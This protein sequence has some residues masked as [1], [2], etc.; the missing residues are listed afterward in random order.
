M[1]VFKTKAGWVK[2]LKDKNIGPFETEREAKA[3]YANPKVKAVKKAED[4]K[5]VPVEIKKE[6]VQKEEVKV[7]SFKKDD[8]GKK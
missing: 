2:R 3:A 7:E 4:K 6:E 8:K 1:D 5:V